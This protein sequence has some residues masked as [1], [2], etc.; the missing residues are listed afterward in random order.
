M[1]Y[2]R[3]LYECGLGHRFHDIVQKNAPP[4]QDCP[5]CD[6]IAHALEPP[7]FPADARSDTQSAPG[8]RGS[9]T[10]AIARFEHNAFVR[11]HFD[12]GAPL[13]TNLKDNTRPGEVAAIPETPNTNETMRMMR[14]MHEQAQQIG[15]K[16]TEGGR[17]MMSLGGGWGGAGAMLPTAGGNASVLSMVHGQNNLPGQRKIVELQSTKK[18]A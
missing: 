15:G 8:I 2:V 9:N 1:S 3:R 14:D 12:N 10:K 6:G 7:H 18:I 4:P 13:L 11:P 16:E 17:A 5:I